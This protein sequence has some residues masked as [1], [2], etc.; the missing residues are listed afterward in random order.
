MSL[1]D[2]HQLDDDGEKTRP[3]AVATRYGTLADLY[4]AIPQ[5]AEV[6]QQR[7]RLD[8]EAL[9]YLMRLRQSTTPEEAITFTSFAIQP[10]LAIWWGHECL[11]MMP[12]ALSDLDRQMMELV[13]GW[14]GRPDTAT[15]VPAIEK[16]RQLV[17]NVLFYINYL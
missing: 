5:L 17:Q 4:G 14:I 7:P 3:P 15:F 12:D 16:P 9:H 11:R 13:A 2:A 8:E 10:K 6:T 1:N